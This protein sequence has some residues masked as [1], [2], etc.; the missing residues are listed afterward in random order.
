MLACSLGLASTSRAQNQVAN[1]QPADAAPAT[2]TNNA[3]NPDRPNGGL[4]ATTGAGTQ[5]QSAAP[6]STNTAPS[7]VATAAEEG[8][9]RL[10]FR[11][12]PL[13]M[14]LNYLSEAAGFIILLE[15]EVK[16]KV[17]VW[18]N[19]PLNKAEAVD[20]L[21]RVLNQNGYAAIRNDRTLTIVSRDAAKTRDIPVRSG[22]EPEK[23]AKSDEMV[24]QI[25]PVRY[26]SAEQLTRDL[27]PLLPTYATLTANQS[28]NALVL[29]D[30]QSNIRRM[31]EIVNALDTSI[32]THSMIKVFSLK[33]ADAKELAA[34]V[35]ELFTP[36][37]QQQQ[38][39][40]RNQFFNR[41]GGGGG[42]GAPGGGGRGGGDNQNSANPATAANRV[43]T[44]ADERTNSLIVSAP[45][46]V[47]PMVESLIAE[48]DVNTT[49][50]TEL[51]VFQLRNS[52]PNEMA[53]LFAEI[54]PD[55]S[56][57]AGG[58]QGFRFGGRG[59]GFPQPQAD[60][61]DRLKKKGRVLAVADPRTSSIIVSAA[62]ELMPQIEMMVA[63]LD[64]SPAKK[65]KVFVY[66]LE[67]A[68][69]LQVEGVLRD[70]FE[71]TSTQ[72]RNNLNNTSAL[73]SR[74]TQNQNNLGSG[75]GTSGLNGLGGGGGQP[76][77]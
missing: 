56:T 29:T 9:L 46:D 49:D 25:I 73:E 31:V 12:V 34:S 17:D 28:G 22:A 52:D 68:D 40:N 42:G 19:Q 58:N 76:L 50:I 30:V 75:L 45:D 23:I 65:Q 67:N 55:D 63:Q 27:Q 59:R 32:S 14:V 20:L 33:F 26:A 72:N 15:T 57:A 44:V 51:R 18:S 35:K 4:G 16:G 13:E 43:V 36:P 54:F 7:T 41:F 70:M 6:N 11:G 69:V 1:A 48:I 66:S 53:A 24:T 37:Q 74:R 64:S 71:R 62:S 10:N 5:R 47:M 8:Q 60:T 3:A 38:G 2:A 39:N 61:S 21:N 77:R